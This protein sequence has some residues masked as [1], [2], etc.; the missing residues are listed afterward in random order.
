MQFNNFNNILN[1]ID[2]VNNKRIKKI[3]DKSS[4]NLKDIFSKKE[5]EYCFSKKNPTQSL[6]VRF[7]AKEA[8]IKAVDSYILE[9][10]LNKIEV[11]NTETGKPQIQIHCS[12]L[13][14]KI[15]KLLKKNNYSINLTLSHEKEFSV[16]HVLIY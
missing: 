14:E 15:K 9:Y 8:I 11:I 16:A 10:D 2:I 1:G 5:I 6:A 13:K 4:E 3:L 12:K 7:A